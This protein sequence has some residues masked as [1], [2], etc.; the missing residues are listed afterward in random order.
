MLFFF[1][2]GC[3]LIL[4]AQIQAYTYKPLLP[5]MIKGGGG[6]LNQSEVAAYTLENLGWYDIIINNLDQAIDHS[7]H[8]H[9]VDSHIVARGNGSM[10]V[11]ASQRLKYNTA[12]PLRRDTYVIGGGSYAISQL[13]IFHSIWCSFEHCWWDSWFIHSLF[14]SRLCQQ[15]ESVDA[16]QSFLAI[17]LTL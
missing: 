6:I 5:Q 14:S 3:H 12:N 2:C 13:S 1:W 16:F 8:L 17:C 11:G 4:T 10:S 9:G 15:R 7:Y